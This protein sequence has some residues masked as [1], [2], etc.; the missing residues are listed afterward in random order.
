MYA[1]ICMYMCIYAD[2]YIYMYTHIYTY[3]YLY[4]YIFTACAFVYVEV[5]GLGLGDWGFTKCRGYVGVIEKG[6]WDSI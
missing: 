6:A 2:A 1:F 5:W 3:V 4:L